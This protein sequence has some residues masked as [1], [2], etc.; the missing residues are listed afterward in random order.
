MNF[1]WDRRKA[2]SNVKKHGVD[3]DEAA[4]I[5][6]DPLALA[7]DDALDPG[8]MLLL[9]LSMRARV[10]VVVHVEIDDATIRIIS[11]RRATSHERRRYE[12]GD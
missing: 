9:G 12:E 10:L 2:A 1:T 5:F 8:R 3:F 11:A 6:A 4:T 7:I